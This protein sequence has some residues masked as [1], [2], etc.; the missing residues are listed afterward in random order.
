MQAKK[1]KKSYQ[2]KI[3]MIFPLSSERWSEH[4]MNGT[5]SQKDAWRGL[6]LGECPLVHVPQRGHQS[7]QKGHINFEGHATQGD[8]EQGWYRSMPTWKWKY[9]GLHTWLGSC[10]EPKSSQLRRGGLKSSRQ[11]AHLW[12][13]VCKESHGQAAA[14]MVDLRWTGVCWGL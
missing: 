1:K 14:L 13:Q 2:F 4:Q 3:L 8:R 11:T 9:Q 6:L 7:L 12:G 5:A 10:W